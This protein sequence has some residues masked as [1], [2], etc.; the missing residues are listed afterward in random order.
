MSAN[1]QIKQFAYKAG[2]LTLI[3]SAIIINEQILRHRLDKQNKDFANQK[4]IL[5]NKIKSL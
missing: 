3:G 4:N 1:K 5:E 2:V